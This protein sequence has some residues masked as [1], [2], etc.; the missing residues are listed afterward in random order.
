M[1]V[2][3]LPVP[4]GSPPWIMKSEMMRWTA[5]SILQ[6]GAR[7]VSESGPVAREWRR[8]GRR[9]LSLMRH[10]LQV[11]WCGAHTCLRPCGMFRVFKVQGCD[12]GGGQNGAVPTAPWRSSSKGTDWRHGREGAGVSTVLDVVPTQLK[13]GGGAALGK[14]SALKVARWFRDR[15]EV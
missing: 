11:S 7:A 10:Q 12:G 3:P 13:C 9:L 2:P 6:Q 4:V 1:L 14:I 15:P 8:L 5:L